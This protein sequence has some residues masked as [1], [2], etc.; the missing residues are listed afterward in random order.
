MPIVRKKA[1]EGRWEYYFVTDEIWKQAGAGKGMLCIGCLEERLGRQLRFNDFKWSC[2]D[3][4]TELD[5]LRLLLRK[6]SDIFDR[7]KEA[8]RQEAAHQISHSKKNKSQPVSR[9]SS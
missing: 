2:F 3:R 9:S 7:F 8:E 6:Y 4:D 1:I 5:T